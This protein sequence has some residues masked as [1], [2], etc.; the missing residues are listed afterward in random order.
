MSE[1]LIC[2][3]PELASN[4]EGPVFDGPKDEPVWSLFVEDKNGDHWEGPSFTRLGASLTYQG[5][6]DLAD[7]LGL[8]GRIIGFSREE[9]SR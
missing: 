6:V 9:L 1:L 7:Q 5:A 8:P 4:A 3:D 2:V